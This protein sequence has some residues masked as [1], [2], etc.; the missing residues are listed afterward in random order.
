ML[1]LIYILTV[2]GKI[3]ILKEKVSVENYGRRCLEVIFKGTIKLTQ[4]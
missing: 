1:N 2:Q 3:D 4:V